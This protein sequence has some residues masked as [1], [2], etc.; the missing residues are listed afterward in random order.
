MIFLCLFIAQTY[1]HNAGKLVEYQL[2]IWTYLRIFGTKR[3]ANN[4]YE[5]N[6]WIII[7][8]CNCNWLEVLGSIM[9]FNQCR[10]N[11]NLANVTPQWNIAMYLTQNVIDGYKGKE[12]KQLKIILKNSV[13]KCKLTYTH[14]RGDIKILPLK[15]SPKCD[16]KTLT[17]FSG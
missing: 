6:R 7:R 8:K 11:L 10:E 3:L 15:K 5:H 12:V 17:N 2:L 16:R 1:A 13:L 9:F 14:Y 4:K